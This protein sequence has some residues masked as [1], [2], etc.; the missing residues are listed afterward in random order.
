MMGKNGERVGPMPNQTNKGPPVNPSS[1]VL[2]EA[3]HRARVQRANA[4]VDAIAKKRGWKMGPVGSH[5]GAA[6]AGKPY[7]MSP[8]QA[9]PF[10][11]DRHPGVDTQEFNQIV[12]QID[13]AKEAPTQGATKRPTSR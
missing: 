4:S 6:N 1:N 11:A 12:G 8:E 2:S 3:D 9:G 7:Y 5:T 13:A 10:L